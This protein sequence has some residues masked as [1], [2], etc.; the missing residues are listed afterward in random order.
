LDPIHQGYAIRDA[1]G[2]AGFNAVLD[3]ALTN[4]TVGSTGTSM[5]RVLVDQTSVE[6]MHL[7]PATTAPTAAPTP[8]G[9][10]SADSA[11]AG[12]AQRPFAFVPDEF[13]VWYIYVAAGGVG[14]ILLVVLLLGCCRLFCDS[15]LRHFPCCCCCCCRKKKRAPVVVRSKKDNVVRTGGVERNNPLQGVEGVSAYAGRSEGGDSEGWSRVTVEGGYHSR[16]NDAELPSAPAM[17][18]PASPQPKPPPMRAPVP[19]AGGPGNS[20][21]SI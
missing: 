16:Q 20:K 1:L 15:C 18:A 5:N 9:E 12:A 7:N 4:L 21:D 11:A 14:G 19:G 8:A 6:T 10:G 17:R 13:N 3:A 2:R